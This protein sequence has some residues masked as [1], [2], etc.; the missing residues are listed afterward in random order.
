MLRYRSDGKQRRY[1]IGEYPGLELA[2]ARIK[3]ATILRSVKKEKT[4]P[5]G[6]LADR[7]AAEATEPIKTFDDL[8]DAY[9]RAC[10]AGL[11]TP[12]GK[13]QSARFLADIEASLKRYLRPKLGRLR[14]FRQ[15]RFR[16]NRH[17][18]RVFRF[19]SDG[20]IDQASSFRR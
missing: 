1:A 8:A 20:M 12:K 4:D 15:L 5:A 7:K 11:W 17:A 10:K 13:R 9:L 19:S 16:L 6:A 2:D 3:A 18:M 14:N